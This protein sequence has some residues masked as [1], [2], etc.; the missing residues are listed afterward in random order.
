M[1]IKKM[2]DE[3]LLK[4]IISAT[5]NFEAEKH[6]KYSEELLKR[7]SLKNKILDWVNR[8]R[9]LNQPVFID[10][11]LKEMDLINNIGKE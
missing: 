8:K 5:I 4:E 3:G 11:F 9:R 2:S 7:L 1:E 10:D 6:H